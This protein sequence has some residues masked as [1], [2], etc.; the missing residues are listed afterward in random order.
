MLATRC[1]AHIWG[2]LQDLRRD[3]LQ[4]NIRLRSKL[5]LLARGYLADKCREDPP[6]PGSIP[7]LCSPGG[8]SDGGRALCMVGCVEKRAR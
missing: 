7:A 1:Y 2:P 4:K 8:V 6:L 5:A 3:E